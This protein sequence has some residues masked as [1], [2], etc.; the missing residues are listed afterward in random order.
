MRPLDGP[1]APRHH[2]DLPT[3]SMLRR[4]FHDIP[5][6]RLEMLARLKYVEGLQTID[7][8]KHSESSV[9]REEVMAVCL[10]NLSPER[11][12]QTLSRGQPLSPAQEIGIRHTLQCQQEAIDYLRER[13]IEPGAGRRVLDGVPGVVNVAVRRRGVVA[14]MRFGRAANRGGSAEQRKCERGESL[15]PTPCSTASFLSSQNFF[16]GAM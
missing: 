16:I 11:L 12:R 10:L 9:E 15:K 6:D 2:P 4:C 7:L 13:G 5:R 14:V 3:A 8:V 1:F